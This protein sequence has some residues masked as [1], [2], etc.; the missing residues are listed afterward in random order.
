MTGPASCAKLPAMASSAERSASDLEALRASNRGK[1]VAIAAVLAAT[2]GALAW[3]YGRTGPIGNSEQAERVIVIPARHWRYKPYL[4]KWGFVAQENRV[5]TLVDELKEKIPDATETGVAAVLKLADWAGYGFVV[6]EDPASVDFAGLNIEGGVP[7]FEKWHRFAVV[8]AGDYAFP[9]KLTVNAKPSEIM[10]GPDLDLLS[11][12]FQQEPL[13]STLRDDPKN[14]PDVIVLKTKVQEGIHAL[15]AIADAEATVAKIADKARALLVDKEQGKPAPTLLGQVHE[16]ITPF[17]LADG[18]TLLLV[19]KA[20]FSSST[21]FN[22]DLDLDNTWHFFHVAA[23]AD[24]LT[25]RTPCTN[26]LGGTLDGSGRRPSFRS[27]PRGDALLVHDD[28]KS[29]LFKLEQGACNFTAL[30]EIS[31]PMFRGEDPGEPHR[32]GR[33]GRARRDGAESVV[34]VARPG[35]EVPLELVRTA[36]I[37]LGLPSWLGDDALAAIGDPEGDQLNDGIY[38]FSPSQPDKALRL[39]AINFDNATGLRQVAPAPDGPQGPRLLVTTWGERA[40][41]Y[42][43]DIPKPLATVFADALALA[44]KQTQP[45]AVRDGMEP[46]I[47]TIDTDGWTFTRLGGEEGNIVDPIA[48][49]DGALVAFT[50]GDEIGLVP[51][52]GGALRMITTNALE[53]HTPMFSADGK[54]VLFRTRFPIEKTNWWLTTARA[55]PT[56]G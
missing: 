15:T 49:P 34:Y 33:V 26:L 43:V 1:F 46:L 38:F 50:S 47:A 29:Q 9:H 55:L 40:G 45:Q 39:D 6:F 56:G 37:D 2:G 5:D 21:G 22:A 36:S 8:S 28:G 53:D 48:S 31:V 16:S 24:P 23:G 18:G 20:R 30:G 12:L 19:R 14:G 11:A 3:W 44:A 52:A 42:R 25:G 27:S 17:A 51:L 13:A 10:N 4:E 32:S 41:L 7:T 54:Q 35:D